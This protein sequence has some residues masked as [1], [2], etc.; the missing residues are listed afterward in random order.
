M[1]LLDFFV[2]ILIPMHPLNA[3]L[4]MLS[5]VVN[6]TLLRYS[7]EDGGFLPFSKGSPVKKNKNYLKIQKIVR[8]M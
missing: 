7:T 5:V 1:S 4:S 3:S 8:R 2:K 6:V